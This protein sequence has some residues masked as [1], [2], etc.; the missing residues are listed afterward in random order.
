MNLSPCSPVCLGKPVNFKDG[1]VYLKKKK[2]KK[3]RQHRLVHL[4]GNQLMFFLSLCILSL[5]FDK[6]VDF[7]SFTSGHLIVLL[8]L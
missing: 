7:M 5:E 6:L 4:M 1:L 2:K 8:T 3:I